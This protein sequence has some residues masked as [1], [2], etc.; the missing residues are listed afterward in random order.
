MLLCGLDSTI[1]FMQI[2]N[3]HRRISAFIIDEIIIKIG[4]QHFWLWIRIEPIHK[5]VLGIDISEERNMFVAKNFIRSLVDK[6][7]DIQFTQIVVRGIL[8]H[9]TFCI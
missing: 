1:W 5:S 6:M 2:Y 4:A 8:K 9:A 7:I 3:R